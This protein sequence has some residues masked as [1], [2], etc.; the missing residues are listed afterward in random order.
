MLTSLVRTIVPVVVAFVVTQAA[1]LGV[2]I[3]EATTAEFVMMAV[4]AVYYTLARV[5]E[6]HWP[7]L[8]LLLGSRRQPTY[9]PGA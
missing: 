8:G 9:E 1:R 5:A 4:F 6:R 2:E 7:V 3:D